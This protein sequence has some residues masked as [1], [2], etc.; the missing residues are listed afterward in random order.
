[1]TMPRIFFI[2][3]P[4][5]AGKDTVG[6]LIES[7]A[8]APVYQAKFAAELKRR[9]HAL[10]GITTVP[11]DHFEGVKD[12]KRL[13]FFGVTPRRAYIAVSERLMKPLHGENVFG[14]LLAADIIENTSSAD[15]VV[16]TD[17][18]F[19]AEAQP[20]I[21]FFGADACAL[22]RVHRPGCTF[23]GDSR[24][25]IELDGVRTFDLHNNA[26]LEMLEH[27]V[28]QILWECGIRPK[29]AE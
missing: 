25:F 19:A 24:S 4:P 21:E 6:K 8:G 29:E 11:H 3:G 5:R 2:N 9:T 14:R 17:S 23:D 20:V 12:C 1:M 10:Y 15:L 16:I 27:G 7:N 22:I 28:R 18:G 26:G 13:E